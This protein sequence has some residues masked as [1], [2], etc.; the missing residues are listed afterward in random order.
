MTI[1]KRPHPQ[2]YHGR[3]KPVEILS[4][5]I[6][7]YSNKRV[8][9]LDLDQEARDIYGLETNQGMDPR[10]LADAE[11]CSRFVDE[12]HARCGL[13]ASFGGYLEDRAFLWQGTYLG[14]TERALHLGIDFNVPAGCAVVVPFDG[15]VV[16]VDDDTPERFGW[17]PRVFVERYE[18]E[19]GGDKTRFVYIFAHLAAIEV[20]PGGHIKAGQQIAS[21]GAPPNNGNWYPHLHL[22][23]VH[24]SV[25]DR[26]RSTDIWKLDGYGVRSE[27]D[28]LV[29]EFPD[30]LSFFE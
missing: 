20:A 8:G 22:Q 16:L 23:K 30:P 12:V 10:S 9:I 29:Q 26:Y 2:P 17:G 15:A 14:G 5:F 25:F 7:E 1:Y 3:K 27:A 11:L 4:A 6:P 21:I 28:V 13:D 19:Q 24:G 18:Q